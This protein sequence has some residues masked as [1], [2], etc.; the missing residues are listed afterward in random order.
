M[1]KTNQH[2]NSLTP[3]E[4]V[5]GNGC[6]E[7][8]RELIK[9]GVDVNKLD[10]YGHSELNRACLGNRVNIVRELIKGNAIL[11]H[12][13][14]YGAG[15][16]YLTFSSQC[17][18]VAKE[19]IKYIH[20]DDLENLYDLHKDIEDNIEKYIAGQ[21]KNKSNYIRDAI[22]LIGIKNREINRRHMNK[23]WKTHVRFLFLATLNNDSILSI[24]P[25]ELINH[26]VSYFPKRIV[27][28]VDS[29]YK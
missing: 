6:V 19:I 3:L 23:E 7:I 5:C 28:E 12:S 18:D 8:L 14:P 16:A 11:T 15:D 22:K 9:K 21:R 25:N 24:I 20:D 2:S 27:F 13:S 29:E 10:R 1:S 17:V 4:I 26:I